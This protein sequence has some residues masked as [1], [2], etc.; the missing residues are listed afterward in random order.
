[1][2]KSAKLTT[3]CDSF[4]CYANLQRSPQIN[5]AF[6]NYSLF[7]SFLLYLRC[8]IILQ[9]WF[10]YDTV[11]QWSFNVLLTHEILQ[12]WLILHW[13]WFIN[14]IEIITKQ[15]LCLFFVCTS[16]RNIIFCESLDDPEKSSLST[17]IRSLINVISPFINIYKVH[18]HII[19][20]TCH[21]LFHFL[22]C[23]SHEYEFVSV[24]W[25]N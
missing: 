7:C 25:S 3:S 11:K 22:T 23:C 4:I 16:F 2:I 15:F 9:E 13:S 20:E 12:F 14:S 18:N 5:V 10:L 24:H 17:V 6:T 19:A 21:C 8:W 1:M